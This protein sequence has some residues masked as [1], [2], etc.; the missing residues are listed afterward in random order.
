LL[1]LFTGAILV[2]LKDVRHNKAWAGTAYKKGDYVIA[3][4]QEPLVEKPNSYKAIAR[5]TAIVKTN[6]I[7][8]T[9]G[10]LILY[11]KKDS[12]LPHLNTVPKSFLKKICMK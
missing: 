3:T 7:H 11:F 8:E 1:L 4:L 5:F 12:L 6:S 9:A 2:W 10:V